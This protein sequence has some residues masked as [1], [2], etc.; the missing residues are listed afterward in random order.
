MIVFYVFFFPE[1]G[2]FLC[3]CLDP[4]W[5]NQT[6][7]LFTKGFRKWLFLLFKPFWG[8]FSLFWC[9]SV[10]SR[11]ISVYCVRIWVVICVDIEVL[12]L[13]FGTYIDCFSGIIGW[14]WAIGEG[15]EVL[16]CRGWAGW[17]PLPS[18]IPFLLTTLILYI[19]YLLYYYSYVTFILLYL[20][21]SCFLSFAFWM[22]L[23][24]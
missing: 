2:L 8:V 1:I 20:F 14:Y 24:C 17:N 18:Y 9:Y 12:F 22:L 6:K 3:F 21:S 15:R 19:P 5:P 23:V 16:Y 7:S 10:N 4:P 11:V 13:S